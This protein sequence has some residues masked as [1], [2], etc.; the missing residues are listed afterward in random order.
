MQGGR[1]VSSGESV[2]KKVFIFWLESV[3]KKVFSAGESTKEG[4]LNLCV[5]RSCLVTNQSQRYMNH[6][7]PLQHSIMCIWQERNV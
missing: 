6:V 4:I 2:P 5:I 3:R 7:T 1:N